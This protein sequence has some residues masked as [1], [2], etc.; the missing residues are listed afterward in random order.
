MAF[1]RAAWPFWVIAVLLFLLWRSG[2]DSAPPSVQHLPAPSVPQAVAG[3]YRAQPSPPHVSAYRP[4]NAPVWQDQHE[5]SRYRHD[6]PPPSTI[7]HSSG[8]PAPEGP[9]YRPLTQQNNPEQ[10]TQR[11]P[12]SAAGYYPDREFSTAPDANWPSKPYMAQAGSSYHPPLRESVGHFAAVPPVYGYR[13]PVDSAGF[14]DSVPSWSPGLRL[15]LPS[16][17]VTPEP[18]HPYAPTPVWQ[19]QPSGSYYRTEENYHSQPPPAWQPYS[20]AA[21]P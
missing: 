4:Q 2:S 6:Q 13:P 3:E 11:T 10:N 18:R 19:A 5:S 8:V 9:R 12:S 20:P 15:S 7:W 16:V 14:A 21:L 17:G 1:T